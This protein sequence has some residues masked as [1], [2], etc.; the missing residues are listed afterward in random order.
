MLTRHH[1]LFKDEK[2]FIKTLLVAFLKAMA[3]NYIA[4]L[5]TDLHSDS[6]AAFALFLKASVGLVYRCEE[7]ENFHE[8]DIKDTAHLPS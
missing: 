2:Q 4:M 5:D 6:E 1:E 8:V 7:C 3:H